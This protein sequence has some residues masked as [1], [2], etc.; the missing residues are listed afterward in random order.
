MSVSRGCGGGGG[1]SHCQGAWQIFLKKPLSK[2]VKKKK[3][4]SCEK[5]M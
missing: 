4:K 5:D 1:K 2:K 3:K